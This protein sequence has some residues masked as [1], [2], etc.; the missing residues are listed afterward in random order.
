MKIRFTKS[1]LAA[2]LPQDKQYQV[3][4]SQSRGLM[5]VVYATGALTF[6]FQGR[7]DGKPRRVKLGPFPDLSITAAR[8]KCD[9]IRGN[10]AQGKPVKASN[11]GGPTFGELWQQYWDEYAVVKKAESSRKH[12]QW[13]WKKLLQP[14]WEMLK[15]S[16]I[17]KPTVLELQIKVSKENGKVTAN[18]MLSLVKK[19]FNH[20]IDAERIESNPAATV[21]KFKE[22]SR[23]R[24]VQGDELPRFFKALGDFPNQDF[25]DF[26]LMCLFVGA[27]QSNVLAM[28]WAQIDF[29]S[30][31]WTIPKT[32]GGQ[33]QR[34]PLVPQ[35]M[36]ILERR[37]NLSKFVFNGCGKSGHLTRPGKAWDRLLKLAGIEDLTMH[38][39]RRSLGSYQAAAGVSELVIGKSLGHSPGS[40]ATA[41]YARLN[42]DPVRQG[43]E[44]AVKAI[45]AASKGQEGKDDE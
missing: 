44:T 23:E 10:V 1:S 31:V 16:N 29:A 40:R 26:W 18:R 43:M 41:I 20:A 4:D 2:L 28:Q 39:L 14:N 34:V 13:Q 7:I 33:S 45:E 17:K 25:A 36:E 38:D 8:A 5:V 42:L 6:F 30:R 15:V 24:F 3:Y 9:G 27:R 19:V 21:K 22:Q 35:A 11:R 12:D 37:R 32:K